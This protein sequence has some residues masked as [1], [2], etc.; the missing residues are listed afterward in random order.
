MMFSWLANP[1]LRLDRV[2]TVRACLA[3]SLCMIV[4]ALPT[5]PFSTDFAT[6]QRSLIE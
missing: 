1:E 4:E 3:H 2:E 6:A 5:L